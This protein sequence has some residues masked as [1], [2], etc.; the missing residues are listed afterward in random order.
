M[1]LWKYPKHNQKART[2]NSSYLKGVV[3]CSL[4]SIEA[5]ESSVLRINFCA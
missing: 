2:A 4:G 5:A 1:T 3:S